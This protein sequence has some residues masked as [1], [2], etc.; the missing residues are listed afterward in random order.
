MIM[1]II[2]QQVLKQTILNINN[3]EYNNNNIKLN[4]Y[5]KTINI[6]LHK[7]FKYFK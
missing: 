7:I 2:K 4:D 5:D 1:L 6:L 3:N